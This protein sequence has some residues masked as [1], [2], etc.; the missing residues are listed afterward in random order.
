MA[1]DV[2][3]RSR[4]R[5]QI[6]DE[7]RRAYEDEIQTSVHKRKK[8]VSKSR[9]VSQFIQDQADYEQKR[10]EKIKEKKEQREKSDIPTFNPSLCTGSLKLLKQGHTSAERVKNEPRVH[11]RL[12][13]L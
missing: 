6:D 8:S 4:R 5:K 9:S 1:H 12:Y 11:D 10:A 2:E 3:H 7:R 13:N